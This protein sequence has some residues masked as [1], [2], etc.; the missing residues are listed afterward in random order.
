VTSPQSPGRRDGRAIVIYTAARAGLLL[1]CLALGRL[2]GLTGPFLLIVALLV[3]GSVSWFVLRRQRMA[4]G[5]VVERRVNRIRD[6]I[7]QRAAAEDAYVDALSG[8]PSQERT[9]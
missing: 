8:A 6:R 7:D 3:S 9:H 5:G 4:M 1:A 2:S